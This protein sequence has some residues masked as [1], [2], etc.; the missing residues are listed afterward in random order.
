MIWAALIQYDWHLIERKIRK[1]D[2][3]R[4]KNMED[5]RRYKRGWPATSPGERLRGK[6]D[7]LISDFKPPELWENKLLLS[8][9]P[10]LWCLI[11]V[12]VAFSY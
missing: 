12:T 11:M 1:T 8:K 7:T 5:A 10:F 6:P 2:A 4:G 3:Y 9:P